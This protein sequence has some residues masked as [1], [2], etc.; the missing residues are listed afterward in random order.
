MAPKIS[1]AT[2]RAL[3]VLAEQDAPGAMTERGE[4]AMDATMDAAISAYAAEAFGGRMARSKAIRTLIAKGAAQVV[5]ERAA[6][7]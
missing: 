6:R 7:A 5:A 1:T 3:Q 4:F 2:S